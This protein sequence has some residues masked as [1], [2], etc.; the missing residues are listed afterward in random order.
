MMA[1]GMCAISFVFVGQIVASSST[2]YSIPWPDSFQGALDV[3]K[4]FLVDVISLTRARP[5]N[6]FVGLVV[7]VMGL[8]LLLLLVRGH[9]C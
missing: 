1:S 4:V 6:Y 3:F 7:L 8:K 5:M 2:S 9:L